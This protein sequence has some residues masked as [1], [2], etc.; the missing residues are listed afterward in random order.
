M[1]KFKTIY[2]LSPKIKWKTFKLLQE[3]LVKDSGPSPLHGDKV[4]WEML[5]DKQIYC[6]F[7][8]EM[9]DD[10]GVGIKL[11]PAKEIQVIS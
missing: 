7:C 9:R 10:M 6:W 5:R 8:D 11:P 1:K 2:V 4:L 3:K